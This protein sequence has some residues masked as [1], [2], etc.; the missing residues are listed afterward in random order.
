M[1]W[2]LVKK[3][4]LLPFLWGEEVTTNGQDPAD[5]SGRDAGDFVLEGCAELGL[6]NGGTSLPGV[7]KKDALGFAALLA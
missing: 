5:S 6:V 2:N 3:L 7:P 1:V 4:P